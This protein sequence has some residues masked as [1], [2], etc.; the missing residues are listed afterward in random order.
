MREYDLYINQNKPSIGL[1]VSKGAGLP[2]I[3]DKADW[4]FDGTAAE[5]LLPPEVVKGVAADGHA[6]RSMD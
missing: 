2:D 6:F 5:D 4:L 1:Y 3:D